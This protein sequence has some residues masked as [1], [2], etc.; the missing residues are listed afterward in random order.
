MS[1]DHEEIM[2]EIDFKID[3]RE[4]FFLPMA[5]LIETGNHIGQNGDGHQRRRCAEQFVKQV[6]LALDGKSPFTPIDFLETSKLQRWFDEFVDWSTQG[7]GLGDLSIKH[8][9]DRQCE[10]HKAMRV[11][12]WS[13]DIH[14]AGF[15]RGPII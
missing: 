9:W 14:L 5:T 2:T 11:Y 3:E 15:D 6:R 13:L 4:S 12:I 8:D 10:L 7:R 1:R